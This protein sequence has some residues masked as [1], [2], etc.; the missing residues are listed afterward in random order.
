ML[1][2]IDFDYESDYTPIFAKNKFPYCREEKRGYTSIVVN[3]QGFNDYKLLN[4]T[5][6]YI[7]NLMNGKNT[8]HDIYEILIKK[9]GETYAKQIKVDLGAILNDFCMN[10][11]ILWKKGGFPGME[12][13]TLDLKN[14]MK[15]KVAFEDDFAK[16]SK[17]Y[18]SV[19][20]CENILDFRNPSSSTELPDSL[21]LRSVLFNMNMIVIYIEDNGILKGSATVLPSHITNTAEIENFICDKNYADK[22]FEGLFKLV[23]KASL[24]L[25]KKFRIYTYENNDIN[26]FM[27]EHGFVFIAKLEK[28]INDMDLMIF[29]AKI[30]K[31]DYEYAE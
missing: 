10:D 8:I 17:F 18:D 26:N 2:R 24:Y 30:K 1:K 19:G 28:E 6:T 12:K 27:L 16:L 29:D 14:N 5:A 7:L 31:E 11:M 4:S 20:Q 23:N 22:L 25:C 21:E 3:N 15:I 9:F 13:F